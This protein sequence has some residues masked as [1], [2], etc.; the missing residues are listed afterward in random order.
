M[1]DG[2]ISGNTARYGGGLFILSGTFTKQ[3]GGIIYGSDADNTLQND[4]TYGG[5][6]GD[7]VYV[8]S[9]PKK[10]NS[11]AG[12]GVTMNSAQSG[13]KGGWE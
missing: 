9:G 12:E 13:S 6:Y 5:S 4:A 10:R 11:T 7:A 2:T 3:Q 1:S 8:G